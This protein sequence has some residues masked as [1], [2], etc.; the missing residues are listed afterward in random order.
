VLV[1]SFDEPHLTGKIAKELTRLRESNIVRLIDAL[2]VR[3]NMD[4]SIDALK[5][6]DL[7]VPE[8]E[9]LG[10][11]VGALL[12]LGL[13][14]EEGMEVGATVGRQ[15]GA[16]GHLIDDDELWDIADSIEPGN[17]AAIALIEHIW[18]EPLRRAIA[19]A[20]GFPV[21][22]EWIHPL[23]LV[24]IGLEAAELDEA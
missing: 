20:G 7:S 8:A 22:N 21:C 5:W 16:D 14:G 24:E 23:D 11:T 3:K 15:A 17:A 4:G 13:A 18:A 10:E 9:D 2:A 6:S 1:V 12:G 19:D